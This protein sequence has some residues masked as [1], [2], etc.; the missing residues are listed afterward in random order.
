MKRLEVGITGGIGSGKSTVAGLFRCLGIAIYDADSHAKRLMTTDGNLV[1]QIRE[2]FGELSYSAEGQLNRAYLASSV[3]SNPEKVKRLNKLVHPAVAAD[4]RHWQAEQSGPYSLK[5][6]ALLLQAAAAPF[7]GKVIVVTAP[8]K[9]RISRVMQRDRRTEQETRDIMN[10]QL[11]ESDMLTRADH[12]INNDGR[13]AL[14][15][16]VLAIHRK[17]SSTGTTEN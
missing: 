11:S 3:F 17:L 4:Y 9:I 16:Q 12:V 2:E 14:I 8:E 13:E 7:A 5:E 1:R 10:R 6:A 15:P